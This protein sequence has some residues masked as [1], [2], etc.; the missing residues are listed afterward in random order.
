MIEFPNQEEPLGETKVVGPSLLG[1]IVHQLREHRK[2]S[3]GELARVAGVDTSLISRIESGKT[4]AL[5]PPNLEAIANALQVKPAYLKE[6]AFGIPPT[7]P[8]EVLKKYT[9]VKEDPLTTFS[10]RKA[11]LKLLDVITSDAEECIRQQAKTLLSQAV[12]WVPVGLEEEA[13]Q[14]LPIE[15]PVGWEEKAQSLL[16][17]VS[18]L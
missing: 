2:M 16:D 4:R 12:H 9:L 10:R 18:R 13:E 6:S 8:A 3:M 14:S 17:T 11:Y 15:M 7:S 5:H 1:F